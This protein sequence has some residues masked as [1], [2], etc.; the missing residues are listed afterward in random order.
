[1]S[2]LGYEVERK[3][4]HGRGRKRRRDGRWKGGGTDRMGMFTSFYLSVWF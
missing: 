2:C 4:G 1:M 3:E